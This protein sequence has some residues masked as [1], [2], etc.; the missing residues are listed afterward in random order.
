MIDVKT[1][2]FDKKRVEQVMESFEDVRSKTHEALVL[3]GV[4]MHLV[5]LYTFGMP[6]EGNLIPEDIVNL[7]RN[8]RKDIILYLHRLGF[9]QREIAR[10]LGGGCYHIVVEALKEE[11][12]KLGSAEEV[13]KEVSD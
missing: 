9:T 4:P 13:T 10:R 1:K 6:S 12:G 11:A 2:D 8:V 3:A 7:Y 5:Y